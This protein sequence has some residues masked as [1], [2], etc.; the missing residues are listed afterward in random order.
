MN[1]SQ[2]DHDR[3]FKELLETFFTEFMELF[4]P[5]AYRTIEFTNL[6]FL[7][8]EVFTD[9]TAGERH[10]ADIIV[11]TRLKKAPGLI[12]VRVEPQAYV[13]KDFNESMVIYF[14]RF[15]E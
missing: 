1:P 4:F 11:E 9:V 3:L 7:Q 5:E 2:I 14:S 15:Y 8:Q 6:K 12:L 10:E 13:Q